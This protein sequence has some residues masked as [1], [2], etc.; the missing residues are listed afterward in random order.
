MFER[1]RYQFGYVRQKSRKTGPHVWVWEYRDRSGSHSVILGTVE[2]MSEVEAWKATESR[3]LII[4]DPQPANQTSFGAV[5]DRYVRQALPERQVTRSPY[6][7]WINTHIKPKWQDVPIAQVKPLPVEL[8]VNDLKLAGKSK[9]HIREMMHLLFNWAMRWELT[10]VERN[11]MSLVRVKGS[12]KRTKVPRILTIKEF[13]LLLAKLTEPYRTMALV[14]LFLGP[15][16]SEIAGLKWNDVDW[17]RSTISIARSW[18]IGEVADTKTEG[19]ARPL[20][21]DSDLA[22]VLREH[23][24]RTKDY[25]SPWM[26]VNPATGNPYWPSKI[27]ENHLVPVGI[28]AG[29]G[30]VGW[31][32]FRHTYSSLLREYEVDIKVQQALLRHADI[33]T[34]MNIYTQAV[35]RALREANRKVVRNILGKQ[36]DIEA[37]VRVPDTTKSFQ[38]S[39]S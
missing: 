26:F 5:I 16:V 31:H 2:E 33:R 21:M 18:V 4:N 35:P 36:G 23:R 29:I 3:R 30:R 27:R 10:P 13:N 19:S 15:R 24:Q 38:I 17:D 12:S 34:T 9:G 7:S 1:K 32:T 25:D 28:A 14:A 39:T 6:V 37:A 8:W 22:I 11:P 20:P